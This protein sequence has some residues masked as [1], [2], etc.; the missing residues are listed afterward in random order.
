VSSPVNSG[1]L[2]QILSRVKQPLGSTE[3]AILLSGQGQE[4]E[5]D[6]VQDEID[7][8]E[9]DERFVQ[10]ET[11][12]HLT[13]N[14]GG[15]VV[16]CVVAFGSQGDG[17]TEVVE[18]DQRVDREGDHGLVLGTSHPRGELEEDVQGFYCDVT[19]VLINKRS[20]S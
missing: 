5:V 1:P 13:D 2:L 18:S 9:G 19:R 16:R 14:T 8:S 15:T 20:R 6:Q 17:D 4:D 10:S 3:S 11:F 7:P 12:G